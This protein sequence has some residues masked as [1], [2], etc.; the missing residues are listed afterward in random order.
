MPTTNQSFINLDPSESIALQNLLTEGRFSDG[1]LYVKNIVDIALQNEGDFSKASEMETLSNWL[2]NAAQINADDG[3]FKSE[4]VRG[5]TEAAGASLGI[6]ITDQQF[7]TASDNLARKVLGDIA[8]DTFIPKVNTIIQADV[9]AAVH[10]LGLPAWAW[11]GTLGDILPS[12]FGGLGGDFNSIPGSSIEDWI[13]NFGSALSANETGALRAIGKYMLGD[14]SGLTTLSGMM[15][16]PQSA[17]IFST[18][19]STLY[20]P[21]PPSSPPR[22]VTRWYLTSTATASKAPASTPSRP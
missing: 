9:N 3:S 21:P 11:A 18:F 2:G 20:T 15:S 22:A 4:F 6:Q 14:L 13:Q 10:D 1:Y 8:G 16:S 19:I 12:A 7:Q 17:V 5:A